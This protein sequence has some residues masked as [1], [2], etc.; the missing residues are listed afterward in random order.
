MKEEG[1]GYQAV[2]LYEKNFQDGHEHAG[3][4]DILQMSFKITLCDLFIYFLF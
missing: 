2:T 3:G 1:W 4:Q